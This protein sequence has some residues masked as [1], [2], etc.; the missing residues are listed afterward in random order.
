MV[1]KVANYESTA[2]KMDRAIQQKEGRMGIKAEDATRHSPLP[3]HHHRVVWPQ[4]QTTITSDTNMSITVGKHPRH[5][6]LYRP[7]WQQTKVTTFG[8]GAESPKQEEVE[9]TPDVPV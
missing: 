8:T 3:P 7:K 2:L 6:H 4:Q 1:I 5:Q 9:V